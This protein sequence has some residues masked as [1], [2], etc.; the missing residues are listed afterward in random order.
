MG[1]NPLLLIHQTVEAHCAS[2][3]GVVGV[4]PPNS[5]GEPTPRALNRNTP[6]IRVSAIRHMTP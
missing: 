4:S 6:N 1:I 2:T 5:F 3:D